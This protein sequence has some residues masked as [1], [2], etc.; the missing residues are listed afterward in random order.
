MHNGLMSVVQQRQTYRFEF[1]SLN[2]FERFL[3]FFRIAHYLEL[4]S[5]AFV[6]PGN[7]QLPIE[8][9]LKGEPVFMFL[10]FSDYDKKFDT[11]RI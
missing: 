2:I 6:R 3:R 1:S 8:P 5:I 11:A 9:E 7:E 10:L 4:P